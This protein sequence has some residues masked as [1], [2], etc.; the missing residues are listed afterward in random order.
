MSFLVKKTISLLEKKKIRIEPNLNERAAKYTEEGGGI[1]NQ[2]RGKNGGSSYEFATANVLWRASLNTLDF[3]PLQSANYS[4]GVLITDWYSSSLNSDS[5]IK[6]QINFKSSE[7]ASSSIEVTSYK[8]TCQKNNCS[9]SKLGSKFNNDIK[10]KILN[11]ARKI[12]LEKKTL[13]KK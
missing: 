4:G 9:T 13:K 3:I 6:I 1:L 10:N 7:L 12:N 5:S 8:K 11:N 2:L